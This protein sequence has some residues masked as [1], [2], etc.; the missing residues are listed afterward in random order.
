MVIYCGL[1][2]NYGSSAAFFRD[3]EL[4]RRGRIPAD[5]HKRKN[6]RPRWLTPADKNALSVSRQ[7]PKKLF[8]RNPVFPI[9]SCGIEIKRSPNGESNEH[10]EIKTPKS[11]FRMHN[12]TRGP[13]DRETSERLT[14]DGVEVVA[15]LYELPL[16]VLLRLAVRP[17]DVESEKVLRRTPS[18]SACEDVPSSPLRVIVGLTTFSR[19][20]IGRAAVKTSLAKGV[21]LL[22]LEQPAPDAAGAAPAPRGTLEDELVLKMR[23]RSRLA[24]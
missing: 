13:M 11:S 19:A 15:D 21:E 7:K 8:C 16:Y 9:E 17:M 1:S 12:L 22:D 23:P 5:S 3:A 2:G 14:H 20:L 24:R 10:Q 4:A 18:G 6:S